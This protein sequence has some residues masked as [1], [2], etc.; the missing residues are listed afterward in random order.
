MCTSDICIPSTQSL[1]QKAF[2]V[3]VPGPNDNI[4][5]NALMLPRNPLPD[6]IVNG[7]QEKIPQSTFQSN[8]CRIKFYSQ[9][10]ASLCL[11]LCLCLLL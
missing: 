11:G 5:G 3:I 1:L 10:F 7:F 6:I 9:V 4:A 2:F 8:P